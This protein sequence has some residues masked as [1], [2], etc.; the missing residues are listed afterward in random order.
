MQKIDKLKSLI[1]MSEI[2]EEAKK[3]IYKALDQDFLKKLVIM[4]DVHAGYD[5]PIGGVALL[6]GM[7]SPSYV[8]YDIGCGMTNITFDISAREVLKDER[9]KVHFFNRIYQ[10]IPTGFESRR[11][12]LNEK[13][14]APY[15]KEHFPR[16][17]LY[18]SFSG[19]KNLTRDINEKLYSQLGTLG[20][21]NHFIEIGC[22]NQDKLSVTIHSGSRNLGHKVASF[23]MKQGRFLEISS[24]LGRAY[25]RDMEFALQFA[26]ANRKYMM[27]IVLEILGF[28]EK[29]RN[30]YLQQRMINEN[31]N[32][33]EV[34][35]DGVL[36]RKGA[37]PAEKGQLGVIPGNMRDGVYITRGLGNEEY[38]QSASHGA[39][40]VMSRKKAK[41]SLQLHDFEYTMKGIIAKVSRHT[42]DEAPFSYKDIGTV[43][44]Y[45]EGI[46]VEVINRVKPLINVKG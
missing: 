31:H 46:V 6:D 17:G 7:I 13:T 30:L 2:E 35:A 8:G 40:R 19:D 20:G 38:L 34:T 16:N 15:L 28:N 32:H 12:S 3:Q 26:L 22:D 4:P 14:V 24:D 10:E 41:S 23:Y 36:H 39:G 21:G 29:E 25:Q 5:L 11:H 37:T 44:N 42:L 9:E 33:A 1:P 18:S 43:L 45:Q 27:D